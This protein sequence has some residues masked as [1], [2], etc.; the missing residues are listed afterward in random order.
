MNSLLKIPLVAFVLLSSFSSVSFAGETK[1]YP[2]ADGL[3]GKVFTGYQGWYRTHGD[4]SGTPWKHYEN[5]YLRFEPGHVGIEYWPDLTEFEE[6]ELYETPFVLADGSAA[7]VFSSVHPKTVARHFRW[8]KEYD[9][10]GAFLQRFAVDVVGFHDQS[11]LLLPSNNTVLT[12]V[13]KAANQEQR[14]Y[15]IMYDLSGMPAGEMKRVIED[16]KKLSA[17]YKFHEDPS[18]LRDGGKL[19]IAIWGVGFNDGRKYKLEDVRELFD[20]LKHDPK[21][22][23]NKILLGVPTHWRSLSNDTVEDPAFHQ[24]LKEADIVLPWYVGRFGGSKRALELE[25]ELYKP[26]YE[27]C[28]KNGL[29]YMPV[30]F[31]GFSWANRY[32]HKGETYD[33][34]PREDGKFL[35]SQAVAAKSAGASCVYIA[36]FDEMD[37]GTQIFKVTSKPPVGESKFLTYEPHASDYYLKL[38]SK[39]SQLMQGR[40]KPDPTLPKID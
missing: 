40:I 26:D 2:A 33:K 38:T 25:D 21:Y 20:F 30:I 22:G 28:K 10:D 3:E 8:M 39:I 11:D 17:T 35:W 31:P 13:Q 18:Y 29:T 27:W 6:D 16:W 24:L 32:R 12:N 4:G 34:I 15:S 9:I 23:G 7:K 1:T 5:P 36:M 19:V 37:E 14:A